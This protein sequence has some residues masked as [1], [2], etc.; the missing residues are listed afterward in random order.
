MQSFKDPLILKIRLVMV[1]ILFLAFKASGQENN[2]KTNNGIRYLA[3]FPM[4]YSDSKE[5]FPLLIFLHGLGEKGNNLEVVNRHGPPQMIKNGTWPKK[6][7]FI[8]ISPQ[9]PMNFGHW[10]E[11]IIDDVLQHLLNTYRIDNTRIYLTG[12][13]LGGIGTWN[14]AI[15]NPEKL[16]AIIPI[17]GKGE[18]KLACNLKNL[19]VWAFHGDQDGIV[20]PQGS[21]NMIDALNNCYDRKNNITKF[22]LYP[23]V[24]HDS[25]T[26]TYKN[27]DIYQW[28]LQFSNKTVDIKDSTNKLSENTSSTASSLKLQELFSLPVSIN[29]SSGLQSYGTSYIWTHNDGGNQPIIYQIDTTGKI[30]KFITITNATNYD[31]EDLAKDQDGN[32]YI[33]DFGNNQNERKSFQIYKIPNPENL[34]KGRIKAEVIEYFYPDQNSFPPSPSQRNFDVEAMIVFNQHIYLFSKNNTEPFN[35][36][37]KLYKL[38]ATPGKYKAELVDSLLLDTN[39]MLEN[40]ITGAD[41]SPDQKQ[42][43]LLTYNKVILLSDFENDDF[44][45][46]D[47]IEIPL[48]ALSQKEGITFKNNTEV[49]ISDEKFKGLIGG[50]LFRLNLSEYLGQ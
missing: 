23:G 9:L 24:K 42:I 50:K 21:I 39:N 29:E 17:C 41:I 2:F 37:T 26:R 19:P 6:L 45:N 30:N 12:I 44:F 32:L 27:L 20:K 3:H 40:V 35:G 33:G 14:Y 10:P 13:S 11:D 47:I 22:T 18:P 7:P 38:P 4:G 5:S 49:F 46:G 28:L 15:H 16:T 1:I 8:V 48:N 36:Y 31:W 25:W 34:E 43:A